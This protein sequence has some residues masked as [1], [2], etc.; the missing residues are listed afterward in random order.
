SG[1]SDQDLQTIFQLDE[2]GATS[3]PYTFKPINDGDWHYVIVSWQKLT[4]HIDLIVDFVRNG[5]LDNFATGEVFSGGGFLPVIRAGEDDTS[6]GGFRGCVSGLDMLG[7]ALDF[8]TE[9]A[10]VSTNPELYLGDVFRWGEL[11]PYGNAL[12]QRPSTAGPNSC[13]NGGVG[14]EC[15]LVQDA[16]PPSVVTCP[17]DISVTTVYNKVEVTWVEPSFTGAVFVSSTHQPGSYFEPG[18]HKVIYSAKDASLNAALC[19]FMVYVNGVDGP[20]ANRVELNLQYSID[21][22]DCPSISGAIDAQAREEI[23]QLRQTW[24]TSVCSTNDCSDATVLIDCSQLPVTSVAVTLEGVQS[25]LNDGTTSLPVDELFLASVLD[26]SVLAFSD[27][28]PSIVL[29]RNE[30]K[31]TVVP[32]CAAGQVVRDGQCGT[33][34]N[35]SS[36]QCDNCPV[37]QYQANY[38]QLTCESCP[39]GRTTDGVGAD[40]AVQCV[41][42]CPT[43]QFYSTTLSSCEPCSLGFYQDQVGQFQCTPCPVGETTGQVGSTSVVSCAEGCDSGEQLLASGVCSPCSVGTYRDRTTSLVCVPCP[44]GYTTPEQGSQ[45]QSNC[46]ILKCPAGSRADDS[47]TVCVE[48]AVG[49]YQPQINTREC[50]QCP[51]GFTTPSAG[52]VSFTDCLRFCPSGQQVV[53]DSCVVCEEA[54][55]K[56]NNLDPLGTCTPC[57]VGYT[58]DGPGAQSLADCDIRNCTAGYRTINLPNGVKDCEVCPPGFYQPQ[59][60]QDSCNVCP[61]QTYTRS[62]AATDVSQCEPYCESGYELVTGTGDCRACAIGYY[63]DNSE[64]IFGVCVLCLDGEFI[65]SG[66]AA[67][68]SAECNLRNCSAGSFRTAQNQCEACAPGSFQPN[69][70]QTSCLD[71]PV[72]TTTSG[73][74][75]ISEDQCFSSCPLGKELVNGTCVD[76]PQGYYKDTVGSNTLCTTCPTGFITAATGAQSSAL[77]TIVA[78]DPGYYRNVN[79]NQCVQCPY[80]QFQPDQWQESCLSCPAGYTT[81]AQGTTADSSCFLDCSAGTYLSTA[82][83]SC[84]PCER[85]FYRDKSSPTQITCVQCPEEFITSTASSVSASDCNIRNCTTPGEFRNPQTNLCVACPIGTYNSEKW[86]DSCTDCPS[87]LT[88]NITGRSVQADCYRDCPSG[89]QLDD[90]TGQCRDCGLGFY[91]DS[92]LTWTCQACP[93]DLTTA[94]VTSTSVSDCSISSCSSGRFYNSSGA[95][96]QDCPRNTYQPNG[97]QSSCLSCPTNKVTLQ[98]STTS[99]DNCLG[100]CEADLD[101][102]SSYA[103]CSNT[104]DG[105]FSCSCRFNYVGSGD[106]CTHVC[107]LE[108]PYCQNGAT[109]SKASDPVCVCTDYYEGSLCTVRRA[110][111][112]TSDNK[113][114]IIVGSSVGGLAFICLLILLLICLVK[115]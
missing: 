72:D 24:G 65:T 98:A 27:I 49:E 66:T 4:G 59:P 83:A 69:K 91:R 102:C 94:R 5:Q 87:G 110:A 76:C 63:K 51:E 2:T 41:D 82:S 74:G 12:I 28:F 6:T 84:I 100:I 73:A 14:P 39:V 99:V 103:S 16:T 22:L 75:A 21:V 61:G 32:V 19:S 96:C 34:F 62:A 9:V 109:C 95:E 107:D 71:C 1:Y 80:G 7:R 11:Q 54:F 78:C 113:N 67:T 40:S 106:V 55:Y 29:N 8:D 18:V 108:E 60:Y 46:S 25:V 93:Q 44:D 3:L 47:N 45:L 115:W 101:N 90:N 38:G 43:G 92:A 15:L 37:G 105:S 42:E 53:G 111:E 97:G 17:E 36:S 13:T 10:R 86:Q 64:D 57:P 77:C 48:C 30:F 85:G 68:S 79:T 70:W 81:F 23:A 26:N 33:S 52:S 50:I 112:Q 31:V 104:D 89:Q 88:T 20:A 56:D 35:S 114:E 58:T